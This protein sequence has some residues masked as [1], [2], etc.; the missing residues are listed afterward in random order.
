[1]YHIWRIS[2]QYEFLCSISVL[3]CTVVTVYTLQGDR[4]LGSICK[5]EHI[6]GCEDAELPLVRAYIVMLL[7]CVRHLHQQGVVHG[8]IKRENML[9][10]MNSILLY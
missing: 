9:L 3:L 10:N 4:D 7:Q 8:D 6:T 2:A 5:H 1:M